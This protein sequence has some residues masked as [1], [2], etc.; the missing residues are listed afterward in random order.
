MKRKM[1]LIEKELLE[2]LKND[3]LKVEIKWLRNSNSKA[4]I[5]NFTNRLLFDTDE[6]LNKDLDAIL[7]YDFDPKSEGAEFAVIRLYNSIL[8]L[9]E[10][11]LI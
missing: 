7:K 1:N 8:K 11:Q 9:P 10:F 6:K 5:N 3:N 2:N 4:I